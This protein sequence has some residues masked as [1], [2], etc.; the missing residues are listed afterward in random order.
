VLEIIVL[1][2]I[3][4]AAFV[5]ASWYAHNRSQ[6]RAR[7]FEDEL[8]QNKTPD[9]ADFEARFDALFEQELAQTSGG[10]E[11]SSEQVQ[12]D[13]FEEA[14]D[15]PNSEP[16]LAP[17]SAEPEQIIP[18]AD[19][20]T[21][22]AVQDWDM[23]VAFTIMAQEDNWF[24]GNQIQSA[25][26]QHDLHFGDMHIFHKYTAGSRKQTLFSVAN[27]LDPG[28]L[29]PDELASLSTPGLLIFTRLPGPINGLTL[30]DD[31]MDVANSLTLTLGGIL[32][33]EKR[34]PVDE[35]NLE[36][37]RTQILEYQL[38]EQA[39]NEQHTHDYLNR[40]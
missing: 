37:M 13:L 33:D 32:C 7:A 8:N 27:I 30:F 18:E 3:I 31:L 28:T 40:H 2:L 5:A 36:R 11:A 16:E 38:A 6:A 25:F 34:E 4:I 15:K 14:V 39:E 12:A 9:E 1:T 23:V 22:S 20:E 19:E 17:M 10:T 26:E 24:S 21:L 35:S 29:A